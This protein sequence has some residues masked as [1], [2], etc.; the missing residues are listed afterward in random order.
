IDGIGGRTAGNVFDY[1][2]YL[3][4][5]DGIPFAL[6]VLFLRRRALAPT[7]K[8]HWK[9]G[10]LG[11]VFS[12]FAYALVIWAMSLTPMTYVSALR[13]TS[14]ILAALIG[15]RVLR[16]PFGRRRIAAAACVAV[17]IILLQVSNGA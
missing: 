4:L 17:G 6:L 15:T 2:V 14:V 10:A 11:G 8:A 5:L 3:F 9:N 1:I 13:E 7:V 12:F 16:E